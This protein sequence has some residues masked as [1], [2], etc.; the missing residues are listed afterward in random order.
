MKMITPTTTQAITESD[1]TPTAPQERDPRKAAGSFETA[2]G[3][4]WFGKDSALAGSV[5]DAEGRW[6]SSC[7]E[8]SPDSGWAALS[9]PD[10]DGVLVLDGAQ[11]SKRQL[12]EGWCYDLQWLAAASRKP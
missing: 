6:V 1:Q 3:R 9:S 8:F 2:H 11:R 10:L 5:L 7:L 4:V 12:I